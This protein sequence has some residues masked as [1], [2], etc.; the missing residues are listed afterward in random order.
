MWR[1]PSTN[2][3][4]DAGQAGRLLN[5]LVVELADTHGSGPCPSNGMEVQI[6]SRAPKIIKSKHT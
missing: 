5:A 2:A 1:N 3:S 6:L 4:H